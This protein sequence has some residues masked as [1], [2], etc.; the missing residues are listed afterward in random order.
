MTGSRRAEEPAGP[1]FPPNRRS[2]LVLAYGVFG[3]T[4]LAWYL[5]AGFYGWS[6]DDEDRDEIP[7]SVR[8]SP[9]GYRSFQ[10]WHSGYQGGK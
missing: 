4:I 7:E 6:I 1:D 5:G 9:G 10:F 3:G 8:Q 2:F